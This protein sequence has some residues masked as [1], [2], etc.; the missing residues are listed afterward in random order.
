MGSAQPSVDYDVDCN[1]EGWTARLR[2]KGLGGLWALGFGQVDS[3]Q[4]A[5]VSESMTA[6]MFN[7]VLFT[8]Y[9][10]L[11]LAAL[12]I[13]PRVCVFIRPTQQQKNR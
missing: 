9:I 3:L 7:A 6:M 8:I 12:S 4:A 1:P 10:V 13:L 5:M 2:V 11:Y